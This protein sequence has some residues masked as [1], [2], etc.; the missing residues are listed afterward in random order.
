M[1]EQVEE[2]IPPVEADEPDD[3]ADLLNMVQDVN[4]KKVVGLDQ[5][6]EHRKANKAQKREIADLKAK[7]AEYAGIDE[8]LQKVLPIA[9]A[10]E[11]NPQLAEAI[12]AALDG[13]RVSRP[14]TEQPENDAEALEVAQSLNLITKDKDGHDIFDVTRAQRILEIGTARAAK[15]LQPEIDRAND[16]TFSMRGEQNLA[17]LY[18]M[19]TPSGELIASDESIKDVMKDS[20]M[21]L[22]ML[23]DPRVARTIGLM[24][25][26]LDREKGR[27]PKEPNEPL[28]LERA[29]HRRPG[30]TVTLTDE[31]KVNA[32]RLGLTEQEVLA[33][34]KLKPNRKGEIDLE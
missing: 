18:Q 1:S 8:R 20:Q 30:S 7:V 3:A 25:A 33:A 29:D 31:Q 4:G 6:I 24:A 28:Y 14:T 21:P 9:E 11:K 34:S 10:V 17:A 13:T 27:T 19:K 32:K 22:R 26:G 16:A 23:S 15:K 2:V 5:L 12:Q